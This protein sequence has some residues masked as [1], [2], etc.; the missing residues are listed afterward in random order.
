MW[1]FHKVSDVYLLLSTRWDG[2]EERRES[3][4]LI[5][6]ILVDEERKYWM[7]NDWI[8]EEFLGK[9]ICL[10]WSVVMWLC[11]CW[12][13]SYWDRCSYRKII[14]YSALNFI[15]TLA[16][17]TIF[18]TFFFFSALK[19]CK[20]TVCF[21]G[22]CWFTYYLRAYL[23]VSSQ[24]FSY[25]VSGHDGELIPCQWPMYLNSVKWKV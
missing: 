2:K 9:D 11:N 5:K 20:D 24:P 19:K 17:F 7:T 8:P 3:L 14:L 21:C 22:T 12:R 13:K 6:Y 23:Y 1:I 4:K 10:S 25:T 15:C 18:I 16:I